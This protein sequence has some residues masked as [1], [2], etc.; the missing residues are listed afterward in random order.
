M[1]REKNIF[2]GSRSAKN[3]VFVSRGHELENTLHKCS[4]P[5]LVK[6]I[7]IKHK[8]FPKL[9][10]YEENIDLCNVG[11]SSKKFHKQGFLKQLEVLVVDEPVNQVVVGKK[12]SE[13][14]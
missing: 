14:V 7:L 1:R 8:Y 10:V 13:F 3:D 9:E 2:Q 6:K 5:K 12:K 4:T 11:M